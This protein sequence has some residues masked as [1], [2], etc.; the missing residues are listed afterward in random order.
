MAQRQ[1]E[2]S[3]AVKKESAAKTETTTKKAPAKAKASTAEFDELSLLAG[4]VKVDEDAVRA[5]TGATNTWITL[6][7]PGGQ[8]TTEGD[9]SCI[10]GLKPGQYCITDR[11]LKFPTLKCTIL[12]MFKIYSEKKAATKDSEMAKTVS[13]WMP[14]DAEQ[15]PVGGSNFERPLKNGN[16]LVPMHWI[17]VYIPEHEEITDALIPFQSIGNKYFSEIEKMVKKS[18]RIASELIVEF[19][20]EAVKNE[21]FKKTNFYAKA[22][23]V[24]RNFT[25]DADGKISLDESDAATVKTILERSKDLQSQYRN[26]RLV[27]KR[28]PQQLLTLLPQGS[29]GAKALPGSTGGYAADADEGEAPV[30]F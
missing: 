29:G 30:K 2:I 21:E 9:P 27:S 19:K 7:Q 13:F 25:L 24:G 14:E 10:K 11:K 6:A 4:E 18:S 12:G 5:M 26:M 23:I 15:I 28:S 22:E 20:S 1:K 17:F 16:V 8:W 3:M